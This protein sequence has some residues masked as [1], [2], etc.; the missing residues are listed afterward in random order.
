ML[1]GEGEHEPEQ[2][3]AGGAEQCGPDRQQGLLNGAG[4]GELVT[5]VMGG[6]GRSVGSGVRL[7]FEFD[8]LREGD[9]ADEQCE[10][11]CDQ[12]GRQPRRESAANTVS[13]HQQVSDTGIRA[14][15][16]RRGTPRGALAAHR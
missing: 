14:D 8:G 12:T 15:G 9:L 3:A 10:H 4:D 5:V 13:D 16:G 11:P 6:L 1:G 2:A 7:L